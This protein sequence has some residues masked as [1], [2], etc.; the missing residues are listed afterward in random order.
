MEAETTAPTAEAT[1]APAPAKKKKGGR[2]FKNAGGKPKPQ[3]AE[4]KDTEIS[5]LDIHCVEYFDD[6]ACLLAEENI[7]S[8]IKETYYTDH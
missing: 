8:D 7:A 2:K 3:V 5:P 1:S 4:L 6:D